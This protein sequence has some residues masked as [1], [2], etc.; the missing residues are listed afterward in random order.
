MIVGKLYKCIS[1]VSADKCVV[2]RGHVIMPIHVYDIHPRWS[3]GRWRDK[4]LG[5]KFLMGEKIAKMKLSKHGHGW[6]RNFERV[7]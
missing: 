2:V 1:P 7:Q 3:G 6:R 5:V 4:A